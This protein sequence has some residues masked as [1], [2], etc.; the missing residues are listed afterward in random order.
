MEVIKK[1][2]PTLRSGGFFSIRG[3]KVVFPETELLDWSFRNWDN[4]G[5]LLVDQVLLKVIS[6]IK[7]G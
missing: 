5:L 7:N 2:L 1:T 3:K 6:E 4:L